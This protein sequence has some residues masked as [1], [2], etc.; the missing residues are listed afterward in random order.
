MRKSAFTLVE[1]LV[2]IAILA[3]LV[4]LLLPADIPDAGQAD[5]GVARVYPRYFQE[6]DWP[7]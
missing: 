7:P 3:T 1:V 6:R 5:Q 2:V 4:G